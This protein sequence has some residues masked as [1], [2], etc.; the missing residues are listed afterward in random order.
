MV[1]VTVQPIISSVRIGGPLG[2]DVSVPSL[3]YVVGTH[4]LTE[5][6]YHWY[7]TNDNGSYM[8]NASYKNSH[9]HEVQCQAVGY[10]NIAVTARNFISQANSSR[11]I[12][13]A[14]SLHDVGVKL[15]GSD[16]GINATGNIVKGS[17]AL[18]CVTLST[19]RSKVIHSWTISGCGNEYNTTLNISTPCLEFPFTDVECFYNVTVD[20]ENP[21]SKITLNLTLEVMETV[22]LGPIKLLSPCVPYV[23]LLMVLELNHNA[24]RPCYSI[25]YGDGSS[26]TVTGTG[27]D[28]NLARTGN[29]MVKTGNETVKLGS[30]NITFGHNYTA[31]GAYFLTVKGYNDVSREEKT[32]KLP[33]NSEPCKQVELSILG[34][35]HDFERPR[36]EHKSAEVSL[37]S[38]IIIECSSSAFVIYSWRIENL[39]TENIL[40]FDN[41]DSEKFHLDIPG[42]FLSY[43]TYR[44]SVEAFLSGM[45]G[46]DGIDEIY[47][48]IIPS[49]LLVINKSFLVYFIATE[50]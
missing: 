23:M 26:E 11:W 17:I 41:L 1:N 27:C 32:I 22:S 35:G 24:T 10:L 21:V 43:G 48:Q 3:M 50:P 36:E 38:S 7:V 8:A 2:I 37:V 30:F 44:V 15:N 20:V 4:N 9:S 16:L 45:F 39:L 5:V 42:N 47:I 40:S 46:T 49:P 6:F 33:V 28:P 14:E 29:E 19:D 12:F 13:C 18:L 34:T 25:D 31:I